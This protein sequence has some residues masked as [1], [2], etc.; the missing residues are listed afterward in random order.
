[1]SHEAARGRLVFVDDNTG[2]VVGELDNKLRI[3][4]DPAL[5]TPGAENAPVVIEIADDEAQE[6]FARVIPPEERDW[7]TNSATLVRYVLS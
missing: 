4:E 7:I 2:E 6:V 5:S 1:M 3:N